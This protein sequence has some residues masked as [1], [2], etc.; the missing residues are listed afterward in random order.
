M[1]DTKLASRRRDTALSI[2]RV[3]TN[4]SNRSKGYWRGDEEGLHVHVY[5]R[6]DREQKG[7]LRLDRGALPGVARRMKEEKI[8]KK[9][10]DEFTAEEL[11][12]IIDTRREEDY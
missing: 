1:K 12:D 9:E 3:T 11:K 2:R 8:M 4:I 6:H 5:K 10:A 7:R